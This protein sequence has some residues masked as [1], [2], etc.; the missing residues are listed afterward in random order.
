MECAN[1]TKKATKVSV[2][3]SSV[4]VNRLSENAKKEFASSNVGCDACNKS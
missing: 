3:K 2:N 4:I 1:N